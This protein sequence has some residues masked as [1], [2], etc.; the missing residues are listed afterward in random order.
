MGDGVVSLIFL[1][2][3]EYDCYIVCILQLGVIMWNDLPASPEYD[4]A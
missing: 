3:F 1:L 4:A 2:H